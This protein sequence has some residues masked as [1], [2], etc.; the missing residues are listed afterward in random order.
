[1]KLTTAISTFSKTKTFYSI[2]DLRDY[3]SSSGISFTGNS[4]KNTLARLKRQGMIYSSG[5]GYYS[6]IKNEVVLDR[7]KLIPMKKRLVDKYPFLP[8][9]LWSTSQIA[10]AYQHVPIVHATFIS[11]EKDTLTSL[12]DFLNSQGFRAFDNPGKSEI[13]KYFQ[14]ES[15][16]IVLRPWVTRQKNQDYFATIETI[17]IDLYIESQR[18]HLMDL[19]EYQRILKYFL[20]HY[21]LNLSYLF[22]YA[23]RR[24]VRPEIAQ[25]A[26]MYTNAN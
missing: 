17:L 25:F 23:D 4:L 6:S 11:S 18:L 13:E 3:L 7:E 24:K 21:R 12:K 19:A 20:T 10:F 9:S 8:F 22:D 14:I 16:T 26:K 1:M 2:E 5:R 15:N